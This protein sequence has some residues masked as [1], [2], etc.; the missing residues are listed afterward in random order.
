MPS[1]GRVVDPALILAEL[2]G[3]RTE[4]NALRD[5]ERKFSNQV[6]HR[7]D[8]GGG[9]RKTEAVARDKPRR[10]AAAI[11]DEKDGSADGGDSVNFA[12]ENV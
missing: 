1:G 9:E 6:S 11:S 10:F 2:D 4:L 5:I 7:S 3:G 8:F 12:R